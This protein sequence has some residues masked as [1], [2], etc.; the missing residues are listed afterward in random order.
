VNVTG[1]AHATHGIVDDVKI[2]ATIA[3]REPFPLVVSGQAL[4]DAWGRF[5]IDVKPRNDGLAVAIDV[6]SLHVTLPEVSHHTLQDLAPSPYVTIGVRHHHGELVPVALAPPQKPKHNPLPV[7]I[8]VNL[9]DDV[10]IVRGDM[11]RMRLTGHPVVH[12]ADQTTMTGTIRLV[13][14]VIDVQGKRF[15]VERGF[16]T[17]LSD[18]SNPNLDVVAGWNAPDGSHVTAQYLGAVKDGR[19]VLSSDPPHTQDEIVALLVFGSTNGPTPSTG[20]S[21]GNL[22]AKAIS[23]GASFATQPF[24]KALEQLTHV[25]IK[26]RVDTSGAAAKSE[27]EVQIAK[28][29][30]A[31]VAYVLGVPPPGADPDLTWLTLAWHATARWSFDFTIGDHGSTIVDSLWHLRY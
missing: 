2:G 3:R 9:G 6:P 24:N 13:R 27:V 14:G 8:A 29:I 5:D 11:L 22:A 25:D 18:P 31:Q 26:V 4:G 28:N 30:S 20:A 10:E 15:E 12:I 16:V 23:T 17:F 1:H 21:G 7:T 19:L